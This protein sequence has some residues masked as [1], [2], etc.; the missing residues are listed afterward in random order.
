MRRGSIDPQY[1][2]HCACNRIVQSREAVICEYCISQILTT[3]IW[4]SFQW[5]RINNFALYLL[6]LKHVE[7]Q[8]SRKKTIT[9]LLAKYVNCLN[10]ETRTWRKLELWIQLSDTS[11]AEVLQTVV[12]HVLHI[13]NK[14]Q[15]LFASTA[16]L[17]QVRPSRHFIKNTQKPFSSANSVYG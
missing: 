7:L 2:Q 5:M 8:R 1:F 17:S 4:W 6:F 12:C 13:V 3:E 15:E 9:T 11:D 10:D 14:E 16:S